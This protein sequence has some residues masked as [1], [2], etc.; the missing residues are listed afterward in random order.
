MECSTSPKV[1]EDPSICGKK[2]LHR[3]WP[4]S[5]SLGWYLFHL[6]SG[7]DDWSWLFFFRILGE[8]EED[9][10]RYPLVI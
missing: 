4:S 7:W 9:W 8:T 2:R 5:N 3:R 10:E 6:I 1:M